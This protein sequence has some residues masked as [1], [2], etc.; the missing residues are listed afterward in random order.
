MVYSIQT[1]ALVGLDPHPVLCEVDLSCQLPA[2]ILV[3]LPSSMTQESRERI[4]AAVQNSG[5]E[6]PARKITV[7]MLPASLPKWGSHFELAMALGILA[8]EARLADGF[9]AFALGELSLS[10]AIRPC[11]WLPAIATWLKSAAEEVRAETGEPL[12]LIAHETDLAHLAV[13]W[14]EAA[15]FC[16]LSSATSLAEAF[17]SMAEASQRLGKGKRVKP[18][19]ISARVPVEHAS[20]ATLAAV[21][22][23]PLGTLAALTAIAGGHHALFAGPHGMGKSM[24]VRA[25][26]EA[27]PALS[28]LERLERATVLTT[29]GDLGGSTSEERAVVNMQTSITRAA[30]EGALLNTGQVLPGELTRAHMGILVAD[31]L[32]EFRRDVIEALRQPLDEGI[33][34][35]QRAK[36]RTM[37]PAKFQFLASTNLCP[38]GVWGLIRKQCRCSKPKLQAYQQKLS[39]P[40]LDRFDLVT[41]VGQRAESERTVNI[42]SDLVPV[43][44]QLT[45][46]SSWEERLKIARETLGARAAVQHPGAVGGMRAAGQQAVAARTYNDDTATPAELWSQFPCPHASDRGRMKLAR[47]ARTIAALM[48]QRREVL[49]LRLADLV[50]SNL[51]AALRSSLPTEKYPVKP[52][53]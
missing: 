22:N 35:L 32:L 37:L 44:K 27:R 42:P 21:K 51:Q 8:A 10:G 41:L 26:C 5:F 34:R 6:W 38:C 47:V 31:E 12:L 28:E 39:G 40:I 2:F 24:L 1:C 29:F 4:R 52:T 33:V 15:Q 53:G 48:G 30:L 14:P 23:E 9:R 17:G 7:N 49:H 50:R 16:E 3:G 11:G 19:L 25:V 36:L 18:K 13:A 43:V 46:P 20:L 45:D